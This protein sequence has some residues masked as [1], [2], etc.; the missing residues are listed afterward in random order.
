MSRVPP[1][2]RVPHRNNSNSTSLAE[3][4]EIQ[5]RRQAELRQHAPIWSP[6]NRQRRC[7]TCDDCLKGYPCLAATL[8]VDEAEDHPGAFA[9]DQRDSQHHHSAAAT[10]RRRSSIAM[11]H[12]ARATSNNASNH[13][14]R[15]SVGMGASSTHSSSVQ[16]RR[17]TMS[18]L[19]LSQQPASQPPQLHATSSSFS[20]NS[21]EFLAV[22][23]QAV[24][25]NDAEGDMT[26]SMQE[27]ELRRHEAELEAQEEELRLRQLA[28]QAEEKTLGLHSEVSV[29]SDGA[30]SSSA[31]LV[32]TAVPEEEQ[33]RSVL[34][35]GPLRFAPPKQTPQNLL[36]ENDDDRSLFQQKLYHLQE[37]WE[38][39]RTSASM[40]RSSGSLPALQQALLLSPQWHS[41]FLWFYAHQSSSDGRLKISMD[42]VW[43]AEKKLKPRFVHLNLSEL[44]FQLYSKT[45]FPVPGLKTKDGHDM[46]YMRPSRYFPNCTPTK[47]IIDNLCYVMNTMLEHSPLAQKEGIG[48]VA[49]MD[50]WTMKNFEVN[51]CYQF[52]MALQGFMVPVKTQLFLIVN[53]PS[54]F[55]AVWKIM[56]PMLAPSFRKRVKIC[57]ESKISKYLAKDYLKHLPNDMKT[58]KANTDQMVVDYIAYRQYVEQGQVTHGINTT[59]HSS[60]HHHH[61]QHQHQQYTD[62]YST[63]SSGNESFSQNN[64]Y[65]DLTN[66][67]GDPDLL[68]MNSF[69][70]RGSSGGDDDDDASIHCD[71]HEDHEEEDSKPSSSSS[72]HISNLPSRWRR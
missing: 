31:F 52:M 71:I 15:S 1:P 49:C 42:K 12:V 50:D 16:A 56:K 53:P 3:M 59:N 37:K 61:H 58:G 8:V 19:L 46:F 28:L 33:A 62:T 64:S 7:G 66:S 60:N 63:C 32:V 14:R 36:F 68:L 45:L 40:S 17:S 18:H 13:S 4:A 35:E 20:T 70:S 2:P 43:K 6:Q 25:V 24:I 5:R 44:K 51:Y 48:F 30:D 47:T 38:F 41:R 69:V 9:V 55:G 23:V 27:R 21:S 11:G 57:P 34:G 26:I 54:W 67:S 39:K 29:Q 65:G 10:P 72:I 22:A